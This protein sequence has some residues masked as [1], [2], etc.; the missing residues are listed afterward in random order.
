MNLLEV[1]DLRAGYGR[2]EVL[3]SIDLDVENGGVVALLG[4]NGAG[5]TTTFRAITGAVRR[6][7]SVVFDGRDLASVTPENAA[8]LRIAHVQEGRGTL[9]ALSVRENLLL[10]AYTQSDAARVR[11]RYA[12][13][14]ERFPRLKARLAQ[15]AGTLSGGE[16]Q[17]L[18]IARALMLEPRLLLLDEPSLGL[19]PLLVREIYALLR[20]INEQD[21]VA[22]LIAEQNAA[23]ALDLAARAY[24]FEAGRVTITGDAAFL[25]ENDEVR[26]SYLGY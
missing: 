6:S 23:L 4:A 14:L 18:A 21:G 11:A 22:M 17:M 20:E 16:Q 9:G 3:F 24:V 25:K 8:R 26:R 15:A 13:M 19:A 1:R 5:K 2:S 10:G 12:M 7:G